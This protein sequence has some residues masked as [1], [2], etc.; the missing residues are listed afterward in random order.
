VDTQRCGAGA[1]LSS[2]HSV[3]ASRPGLF[4][5]GPSGLTFSQNIQTRGTDAR[6][7]GFVE[8]R[9]RNWLGPLGEHKVHKSV[10]FCVMAGTAMT[11]NIVAWAS[12]P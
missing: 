10:K 3:P 5:A 1:H 11:Q 2:D 4:K 9:A 12:R 6:A 7:T 8:F